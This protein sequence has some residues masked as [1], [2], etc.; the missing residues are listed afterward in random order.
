MRARVLFLSCL[1]AAAAAAGLWLA[2]LGLPAGDGLPPRSLEERVRQYLITHPEVLNEAADAYQR[3]RERERSAE[4]LKLLTELRGRVRSA[5]DLPVLGNPEGDVTVVE[6]FDYRCPYCKR[7][8][9]ELRRLVGG[10][11]K[12]RLVFKEF[13]ILGPDSLIASRAAI[14]SRKQG[15]YL[16]FHIALMSHQ[17]ALDAETVMAIAREAGLDTARLRAD[18][19]DREASEILKETQALA[20]RLGIEATPTLIIGDEVHAGYADLDTLKRLVA[21]ARAGCKSC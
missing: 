19:E 2:V 18:M 3:R 9:E 21:R 5:G 1:L 6:F 13:P 8:L 4:T 15:K 17:G 20:V 7:T 16:A 14:A 12:L 11:P 10:D